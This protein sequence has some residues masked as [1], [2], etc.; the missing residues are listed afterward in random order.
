V[1]PALTNKLLVLTIC[2][3][4][5]SLAL[6]G[7]GR[8]T[9]AG[10]SVGAVASESGGASAGP[11][12][13]DVR[14]PWRAPLRT[15]ALAARAYAETCTLE[16]PTAFTFDTMYFVE[17]CDTGAAPTTL[18]AAG[19]AFEAALRDHAPPDAETARA[20]AAARTFH[21]FVDSIRR[22][23]VSR[24]TALAYQRFVEAYRVFEPATDLPLVPDRLWYEY[25]EKIPNASG[26]YRSSSRDCV[27]PVRYRPSHCTPATPYVK[28]SHYE[29][30]KLLGKPPRWQQG[31]QGPYLLSW[32]PVVDEPMPAPAASK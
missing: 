24:G 15:Y 16:F 26:H 22:T 25:T 32:P 23:Q 18:L 12:P 4:G 17:A 20:R 28:L 30:R 10:T 9:I 5:A 3:L 19:E 8:K 21:A 11:A 31:P 29:Y 7:C 2:G 6:V 14:A 27:D 1:S 13:V